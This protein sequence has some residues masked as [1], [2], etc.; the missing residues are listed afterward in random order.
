VAAMVVR[1]A[2]FVAD[3]GKDDGVANFFELAERTVGLT[4]HHRC[5]RRAV[6]YI[7]ISNGDADDL[8]RGSPAHRMVNETV[9]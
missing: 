3:I 8:Q 9:D 1:L 4:A 6:D 5:G 2:I 7:S